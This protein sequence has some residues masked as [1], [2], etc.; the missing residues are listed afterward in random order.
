MALCGSQR[1][2]AKQAQILRR[3][4]KGLGFEETE[5]LLEGARLLGW[6][7]LRSLGSKDGAGRRWAKEAYWRHQNSRGNKGSLP[8]SVKDVLRGMLT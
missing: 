8:E 7:E 4:F 5:H 2:F 3:L 6:H 1:A